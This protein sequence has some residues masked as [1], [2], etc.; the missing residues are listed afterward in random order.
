MA[1]D[2]IERGSAGSRNAAV[3]PEWSLESSTSP[4]IASARTRETLRPMP[5]PRTFSSSER[6]KYQSNAFFDSGAVV[7]DRHDDPLL[8]GA[9]VDHH[10]GS[11]MIHRV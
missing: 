7:D 4:P 6:W 5:A 11:T 8:V 3:V 10:V 9:A 2:L 1:E